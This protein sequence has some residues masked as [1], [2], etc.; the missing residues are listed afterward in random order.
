MDFTAYLSIL[1][2]HRLRFP[3]SDQFEDIAEGAE[4]RVKRI[5][6]VEMRLAKTGELAYRGGFEIS[7]VLRRDR[8]LRRVYA[9]CWHAH[10]DESAAM[11][12]LYSRL[13]AEAIAIRSTAGMLAECVKAAPDPITIGRVRYT[14]NFHSETEVNL[15]LRERMLRKSGAFEHEREVRALRI[16]E[17]ERT[18]DSYY[19]PLPD[20]SS[21]FH[22]VYVSPL[23]ARWFVNLCKSVTRKY[24]RDI[25][26]TTSRLA[27]RSGTPTSRRVISKSMR[28][29]GRGR[30]FRIKSMA[31][32]ESS[33]R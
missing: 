14:Q 10:D 26:V 24:S 2:Y 15:P 19:C 12:R 11:W 27:F 32:G 7:D 5:S 9:S 21:L 17:S 33:R 3:R 8:D 28:M 16:F 4:V 29:V 13:H 23:A 31:R 22:V 20:P 18:R 6:R 30:T 25:L 1:H